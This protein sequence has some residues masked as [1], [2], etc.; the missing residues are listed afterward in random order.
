[1]KAGVAV[2]EIDFG[3]EESALGITVTKTRL[4]AI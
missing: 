3:T 4:M 1:M 2:V